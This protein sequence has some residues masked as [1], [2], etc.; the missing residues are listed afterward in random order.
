MHTHRRERDAQLVGD[1]L[2]AVAAK[3]PRGDLRF[4]RRQIIDVLQIGRRQIGL[5]LVVD[6]QNQCGR[7]GR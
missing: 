6:D 7:R 2:Q 1:I 4:C 5:A 3:D